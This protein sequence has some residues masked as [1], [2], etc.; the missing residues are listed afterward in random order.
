MSMSG[1]SEHTRGRPGQLHEE[2]DI[3]LLGGAIHGEA[4]EYPTSER[5]IPTPMSPYAITKYAPSSTRLLQASA[6]PDYT[7]LRYANIYGP[8]QIPHGE[9]GV[10]RY[11]WTGLLTAARAP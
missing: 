5:Y 4:K 6:R 2:G 10:V 7:V 8:R 11:S 1:V 3:H 9:A